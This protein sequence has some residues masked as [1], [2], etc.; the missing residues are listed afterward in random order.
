[1][2]SL[3]SGKIVKRLPIFFLLVMGFSLSTKAQDYGTFEWDILRIGAIYP[4]DK[5]TFDSG[6]SVST[7]PRFNITNNFS[8]GLRLAVDVYGET[9]AEQIVDVGVST[10][11]YLLGDYY[12]SNKGNKRAFAGLGIGKH[13][14]LE[15]TARVD[16][17][18]E[19]TEEETRDFGTYYGVTPR[20]G[21]EFGILRISGE[22]N[23]T[24]DKA[25]PDVLGIH[26][27][28]TIGG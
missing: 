9:P 23:F 13:A 8:A 20:I 25:V 15:V 11:I 24:L 3:I 7:G 27:G 1:M 5:T 10:S 16:E 12:F 18:G 6:V 17:N 4:S 28:L 26:M 2:T 14:G 21:Y 19:I 22:Y